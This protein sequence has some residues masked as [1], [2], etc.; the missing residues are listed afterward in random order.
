MKHNSDLYKLRRVDSD[1]KLY[2]N[3]RSCEFKSTS[4]N[5]EEVTLL[6]VGFSF[7]S[8]HVFSRS[9]AGSRGFPSAG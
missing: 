5:Q 9:A 1:V 2:L 3:T 7:F 4:F 6:C 8:V